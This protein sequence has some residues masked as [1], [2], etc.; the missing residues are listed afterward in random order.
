MT[1]QA[2]QSLDAHIAAVVRRAP[3]LTPEQTA[4]LRAILT[5]PM[6]SGEGNSVVSESGAPAA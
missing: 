1:P 5:D 3:A 6:S 4:T 2:R